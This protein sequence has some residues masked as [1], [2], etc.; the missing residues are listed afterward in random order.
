MTTQTYQ[1]A[2]QR[3]LAQAKQE[4][5]AGDLPQASEKGWGATAQ[6]LKAIA[7]QRGWEHSRHRHYHRSVSR[8]RSETGDGDIAH[9]FAVASVLH[10]NFYEDQMEAHDVAH[11]L[12]DVEVLMDKLIPL[13]SQT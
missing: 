4:L 7:E 11:A 5:A 3:F 6:I 1:Q 9:L 10:E 8:L 2:S 13:L 12:V